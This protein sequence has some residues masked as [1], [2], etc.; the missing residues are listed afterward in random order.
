MAVFEKAKPMAIRVTNPAHLYRHCETVELSL[1]RLSSRGLRATKLAV[2]D[3]AGSRI[4]D[5]QVYASES[6]QVPDTLL[7]EADLGPGESRTYHIVDASAS[8]AVPQPIVKTYARQIGERYHD[9]AWESDRIA[10]RMYHQD[11]LAAE[12]TVS[13]GVD[14]WVK[15]TRSLVINKW[16]KNGDYHNDHGE[17]LDDYR[18]GGSRGCGGCGALGAH[19]EY[20]TNKVLGA[21]SIT[22]TTIP[23]ACHLNYDAWDA[24]KRKVS[25]TKRI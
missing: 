18:V 12:G 24:G 22:P 8:A 17:G 21:R 13:S 10:H 3:G 5:S 16:Y 23:P 15:S 25:E 20:L 19:T 9:M 7:F 4:L 11:L 6:G 2:M 14:V 1:S